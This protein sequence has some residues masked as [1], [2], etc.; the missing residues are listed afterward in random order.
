MKGSER[1]AWAAAGFLL[2]TTVMALGLGGPEYTNY[3]P[4]HVRAGGF[5]VFDR[6]RG[7]AVMDVE[8]EIN[9]LSQIAAAHGRMIDDVQVLLLRLYDNSPLKASDDK[10]RVEQ[11][12]VREA[13][14]REAREHAE[15]VAQLQAIQ[16]ELAKAR[17]E[18]KDAEEQR[19]LD[20]M[21]NSIPDHSWENEKLR[22]ELRK[23]N[24]ALRGN[25]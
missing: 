11:A 3:S 25:P 17:K 21:L 4:K 2:A 20:A 23:I 8:K 6:T 16:E 13:Q 19:R 18:A 12:K 15:L 7:G 10:A 14:E 9:E 22:R 1:I 24:D 5:Q